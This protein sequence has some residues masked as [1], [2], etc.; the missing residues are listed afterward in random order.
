M[1]PGSQ[2][3]TY[4][5]TKKG[6]YCSSCRHAIDLLRNV[7][8]PIF[9]THTGNKPW[10]S[11]TWKNN[12]PR[13]HQWSHHG[14]LHVALPAL[15]LCRTSCPTTTNSSPSPTAAADC[16]YSKGVLAPVLPIQLIY[17]SCCWETKV[18]YE[19]GACKNFVYILCTLSKET[20]V[21]RGGVYII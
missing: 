2:K 10:L 1:V 19:L 8:T 16:M 20:K 12:L 5:E 18:P 21:G 9:S 15:K 13:V 11:K 7:T 4:T 3:Q 14:V 6:T 17:T